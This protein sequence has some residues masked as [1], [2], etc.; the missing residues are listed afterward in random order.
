MLAEC[1][2]ARAQALR[3]EAGRGGCEG[4]SVADAVVLAA[5]RLGLEPP[6]SGSV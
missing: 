6:A 1:L 4:L 5:V 2:A 3:V